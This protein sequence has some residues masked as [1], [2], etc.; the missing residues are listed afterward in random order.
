[1]IAIML[2]MA[3]VA[4]QN[5]PPLFQKKWKLL[6]FQLLYF[7]FC[8][9]LHCSSNCGDNDFVKPKSRE[10]PMEKKLAGFSC[11]YR[12][13]RKNLEIVLTPHRG[14]IKQ[15]IRNHSSARYMV[16]WLRESSEK[17]TPQVTRREGTLTTRIE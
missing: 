8:S 5:V 6:R 2:H 15:K 13:I 16:S 7:S 1:M 10:K 12:M 3:N 11:Q 9:S 4:T 14:A 17:P